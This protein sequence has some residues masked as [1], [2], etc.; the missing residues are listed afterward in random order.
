MPEQHDEQ[1]TIRYIRCPAC[2]MP[3]PASSKDCSRCGEPLQP[4]AASPSPPPKAAPPAE[5]VEVTC[6]REANSAASAARLFR[7]KNQRLKHR[8]RR[9]VRQRPRLLLRLP[10]R[11]R[12]RLRRRPRSR[13]RL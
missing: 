3:N 13:S 6:L 9:H 4:A 11:N 1:G 10:R 2:G 5:S 7:R 12:Q 8:A